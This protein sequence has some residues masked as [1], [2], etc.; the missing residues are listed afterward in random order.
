V[1]KQLV[2]GM[3]R[4]GMGRGGMVTQKCRRM[5]RST[6]MGQWTYLGQLNGQTLEKPRMDL[7]E[8]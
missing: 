8:T 1:R 2:P 5:E 4:E 3:R 7:E 6:R